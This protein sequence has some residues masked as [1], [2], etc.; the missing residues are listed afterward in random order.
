MST[1]VLAC[2]TLSHPAVALAEGVPFERIAP[3]GSA[4]ILIARNAK[5]TLERV[6]ASPVGQ[7]F[8]AP[9]I[10]SFVGPANEE[11]KRE[12]SK[13]LREMGIEADTIPWPGPLGLS[14]FVEHNEELDAPELGVL[15]HADYEERADAASTIFDGLVRTL[16]KDAGKPFEQVEVAGGVKATRIPLPE[17]EESG[18]PT[19]PQPPRRGRPRGIDAIDEFASAPEAIFFARHGTQFFLATSVPVLEEAMAAAAGKGGASVADSEA[20]AGVAAM[21]GDPEVAL[22]V[23]PEPLEVLA[24]PFLAGP[25][26]SGKVLISKL[27]GGIKALAL[28]GAAPGGDAPITFGSAVFAPGVRSGVLEIVSESTPI[29]TPPAT[30][31][32]RAISFQRLNVRFS[33]ILELIE[34]VVASLPDNEADAIEGLLAP[35]Q[36]GLEQGLA[37][38]GPAVFTVTEPSRGTEEL[39]RTLT[40]M[41][42]SNEKVANALLATMLPQAGMMPRDF[43]GH[44]VYSGEGMPMEVGLGGGA[45]LVGTP[46]AVQQGLRAAADPGAKTLSDDAIYLRCQQAVPAGA[47]CAW[48]YTDMASSLTEQ[49]EAMKKA[50][51]EAEAAPANGEVEEEDPFAVAIPALPY[52]GLVEKAVEKIDAQLIARY[53]GPIVWD[54]RANP[55]GIIMRGAWLRPRSEQ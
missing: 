55:N 26:E 17:E 53:F 2:I 14:L 48:G 13:K 1:V 11:A 22:V 34:G 45:M 50:M 41:K 47:V 51:H 52:D 21:T 54:V 16:E 3:K 46:E 38:L 9:E 42:C 19:Q 43:K 35:F 36:A 4:V 32:E 39:P 24:E 7:F 12:Q 5:A 6:D 37:S 44:I 28:F 29:E 49:V 8:A 10:A 18:A 20:F 30:L 31:G 15:A 23:I 40:A 33:K 25:M 27:F